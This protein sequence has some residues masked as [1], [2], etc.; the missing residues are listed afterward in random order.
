MAGDAW[1]KASPE[2]T[3]VAIHVPRCLQRGGPSQLPDDIALDGF[4][5]SRFFRRRKSFARHPAPRRGQYIELDC[6]LLVSRVAIAFDGPYFIVPCGAPM[7]RRTLANQE[8]LC[9]APFTGRISA[10][11]QELEEFVHA[12]LMRLSI[13]IKIMAANQ[14]TPCF[15]ARVRRC[16]GIN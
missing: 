15:S 10:D 3:L 4:G 9:D 8:S 13:V 16:S 14:T 1:R 2:I 6:P 12:Q 11:A 7:M 5:C